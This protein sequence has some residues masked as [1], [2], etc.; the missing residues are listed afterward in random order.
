MSGG[1]EEVLVLIDG[2]ETG[3]EDIVLGGGVGNCGLCR[4]YTFLPFRP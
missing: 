2:G 3:A 1:A 4:Q